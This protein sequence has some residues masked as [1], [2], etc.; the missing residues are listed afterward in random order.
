MLKP[1]NDV[2]HFDSIF[3]LAI[4]VISNFKPSRMHLPIWHIG[5]QSTD[6]QPEAVYYQ[7]EFY[8][9]LFSVTCGNVRFSP[10]FASGKGT[11]V[12]GCVDFFIPATKWGI[13]ITRDGNQLQEHSSR[14]ATSGAY[15]AWLK[16]GDMDDY[17]LLDC[18]SS[19]P[20]KAH[21]SMISSFWAAPTVI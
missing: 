15:G 21:P 7:D 5:S 20:E 2:P 12:A 14:F 16:S 8:R 10:G 13:E 3:A 9:S 19:T 4:A 1:T 6:Q 18:R 17:I 11:K